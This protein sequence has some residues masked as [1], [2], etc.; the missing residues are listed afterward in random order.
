MSER[1]D[2]A[3]F[4][5][6]QDA[7]ANGG[8]TYEMALAELRAGEKKTHWM[9]FIFPQL[10]GLGTSEMSLKYAVVSLGEA[11]A[12]ITHPV[13]GSRLRECVATLN[14]LED[15]TAFQIFGR[16]D[17]R[18]FRACI[19][20]FGYASGDNKVFEA[21]LNRFFPGGVDK[22]TVKMLGF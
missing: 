10:R 11:R 4:V 6:A 5:R 20:L 19:T 7:P 17:D 3:R 22:Q 21:A 18:K 9:W 8:T 1:Y 13:L 14:G 16:P 2:L 12:Y 15:R